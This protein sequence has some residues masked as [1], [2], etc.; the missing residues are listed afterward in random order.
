MVTSKSL[1]NLRGQTGLVSPSIDVSVNALLGFLGPLSD[2]GPLGPG[3]VLQNNGPIGLT[4]WHPS[5]WIS[6]FDWKKWAKIFTRD[7]GP[8]SKDGPLSLHG[9]LM[10]EAYKEILPSSVPYG[11]QFQA[12]GIFGIL[13]PKGAL[14]PYGH[15]GPR[16]V[17]GAH[18][19]VRNPKTGAFEHLGKEETT[20]LVPGVDGKLV[21]LDLCEEYVEDYARKLSKEGK[22][23]ANFLF[24]ANLK[25]NQEDIVFHAK[26]NTWVNIVVSP[27][28]FLDRFSFDILTADGKLVAQVNSGSN[29]DF[30]QIKVPKDM[31]IR[32]RVKSDGALSYNPGY[33]MVVSD[34]PGTPEELPLDGPH[35]MRFQ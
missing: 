19:Y 18:G 21:E 17:N 15:L 12:G 6:G 23:N 30:A 1:E 11:P 27:Q 31:D 3:G 34:A 33:R 4:W 5:N 16:G 10:E 14:G 8:L 9:P 35:L 29:Y 22:L 13:G 7:G 20:M 28:S 24:D 26:S 25:P 2:Y 32:I